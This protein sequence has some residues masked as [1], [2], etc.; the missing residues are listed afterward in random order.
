MGG[1]VRDGGG[2]NGRMQYFDSLSYV[3]VSKEKT[4]SWDWMCFK[5][6]HNAMLCCELVR[7]DRML[8]STC[9]CTSRITTHVGVPYCEALHTCVA[10]WRRKTPT[11]LAIPHHIALPLEY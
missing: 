9:A 3:T 5:H 10:F 6:F 1:R 4:K 11:P 2:R 7:T 8:Q